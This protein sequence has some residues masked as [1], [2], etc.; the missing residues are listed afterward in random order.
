MFI[1]AFFYSLMKK[2]LKYL[3]QRE[4]K[5]GGAKCLKG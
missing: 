4:E 2:Y 5:K 1:E 3:S